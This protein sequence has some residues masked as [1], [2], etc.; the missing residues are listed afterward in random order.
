M[1]E[2]FAAGLT[3]LPTAARVSR[4][5]GAIRWRVISS[6]ISAVV[7]VIFVVVLGESWPLGWLVFIAA[8]WVLSTAF[9]MGLSIWQLHAAKKDLAGIPE[10]VAFYL[11]PQGV[12]FVYPEAVRVAWADVTALKLAGRGFGPG[13]R[14]VLEAQGTDV[15]AVPLSF[16]DA[17]AEVIDSAA[18]AYSLG[19]IRL[20]TVAL[21]N[22][23]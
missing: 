19:R 13:P 17:T 20:D 23:L 12:E 22:V 5:R 7:V 1:Q 21:D 4:Q 2:R 11:G 3:P 9:W 14:V 18:R 16:L 6:I 15:A 8:A 10:G